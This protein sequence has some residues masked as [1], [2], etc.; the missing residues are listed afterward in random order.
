MQNTLD[1]RILQ[2]MSDKSEYGEWWEAR[3]IGLGLGFPAPRAAQ[4][5][6]YALR[7]LVTIGKLEEKR[8]EPSIIYRMK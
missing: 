2:F 6:G 1:N 4:A 8:E 7:R 5:L 3:E